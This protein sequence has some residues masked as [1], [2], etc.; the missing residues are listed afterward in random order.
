M[1][2][3]TYQYCNGYNIEFLDE[4][5]IKLSIKD[6]NLVVDLLSQRLLNPYP[7]SSPLFYVLS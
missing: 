4:Y 2:R 5:I 1:D 6:R 3:Q 7:L